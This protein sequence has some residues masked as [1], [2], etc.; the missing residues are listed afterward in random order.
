MSDIANLNALRL[1]DTGITHVQA[2][3]DAEQP[4]VAGAKISGTTKVHVVKSK[5]GMVEVQAE[6]EVYWIPQG[7]FRANIK[8]YAVWEGT[9]EESGAVN[10]EN[11]SV[12]V[13]PVLSLISL[14][15][16]V[17][18]QGAHGTPVITPPFAEEGQI[19]FEDQSTL[20]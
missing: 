11:S 13:V 20:S 18:T 12:L 17:I 19:E 16:S 4:L 2:D 1:V 10:K 6:R 14:I 15:L 8:G 3:L 9:S 5:N 7:P